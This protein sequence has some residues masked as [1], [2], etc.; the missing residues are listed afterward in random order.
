MARVALSRRLK[1]SWALLNE[2]LEEFSKDRADLM[3]AAIAFYSLLSIAPLILVA[4]ALAGLVLGSGAAHEE[5]SRLLHESMG[6]NAARTVESWVD[7]S[8]ESGDIASLVGVTLALFAASRLVTQLRSALNQIW[9]VDEASAAS[10]KD[11][12]TGYIRRRLFAFALVAASAPLLLL[13]FASR[14]LLT[15]LHETLF[16]NLPLAGIAVQVTQLAFSFALVMLMTAIIFRIVPDARTPRRSI[17]VG[18]ALTSALF[19]IGNVLVGLY[20]GRA[21]VSA[22]YGAAGSVVVVLLWLSF[23]ATM[24]LFG[25]EF[26]QVHAK[27]YGKP[28]PERPA[29]SPRAGVPSPAGRVRTAP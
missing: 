13:V 19:N 6:P 16:R 17:L 18:S 5:V 14:A 25:A 11:S 12:V 1:Q 15:G 23:S 10:F 7:E 3:A 9:N 8:A 2:T 29:P 28:T 22:T 26:T 21:S 4:V 27:H 20:L 24:F